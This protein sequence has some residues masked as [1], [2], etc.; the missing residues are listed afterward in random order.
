MRTFCIPSESVLAY[1]ISNECKHEKEVKVES[2]QE[3]D[4]GKFSPK[5]IREIICVAKSMY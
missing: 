1:L 4:Q 5:S 3:R 2:P